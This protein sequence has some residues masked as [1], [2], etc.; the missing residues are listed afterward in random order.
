MEQ[1]R[2]LNER[3]I[4]S[5]N[6]SKIDTSLMINIADIKTSKLEYKEEV[7]T[8]LI[9]AENFLSEFDWCIKIID[10]WLAASFGYILNIFY[11]RIHPDYRS[12]QDEFVWIIVG[13]IP[14]AYIDVVS[15]PTAFDALKSYINVMQDWVDNVSNGNSVKYCYPVNVPPKKKYADMLAIRLKLLKEDYLYKIKHTIMEQEIMHKENLLMRRN[16]TK[17][18]L[19][20][21]IMVGNLL[22]SSCSASFRLGIGMYNTDYIVNTKTN[23]KMEC[24]WY[25][26]W[27]EELGG[28]PHGSIILYFDDTI[29]NAQ[30]VNERFNVISSCC[31]FYQQSYGRP[32]HYYKTTLKNIVL[33]ANNKDTISWELKNLKSSIYDSTMKDVPAW[34][35]YVCVDS[36]SSFTKDSLPWVMRASGQGSDWRASFFLYTESIDIRKVRKLRAEVTVQ[37]DDYIITR[38][39]KVR[40]K[41]LIWP[42]P[43]QGF[44][45]YGPKDIEIWIF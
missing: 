8:L 41:F 10:G 13:D 22:L 35:S 39:T 3:N 42:E 27:P 29:T 40:R 38:V 43:R 23:E 16:R 4:V 31:S 33:I 7:E 18:V 45:W 24:N 17:R 20:L 11:F 34:L 37:Y 15:A 25:Q 44:Q 32:T 6:F 1:E 9:E 14:S 12:C 19:L 5:M 26:S 21:L 36:M 2:M 28:T 30:G